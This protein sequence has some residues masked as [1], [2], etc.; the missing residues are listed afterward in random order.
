MAATQDA[1]AA[2][3][4]RTVVLLLSIVAMFFVGIFVRRWLWA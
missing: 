1:R 4:T 2:G 3:K